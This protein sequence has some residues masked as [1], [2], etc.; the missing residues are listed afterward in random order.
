MHLGIVTDL[1]EEASGPI[2][3]GILEYSGNPKVLEKRVVP[4]FREK[5]RQHT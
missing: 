5:A 4:V 2:D 3:L 1:A